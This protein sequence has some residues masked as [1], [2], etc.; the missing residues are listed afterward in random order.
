MRRLFFVG[1]A[2]LGCI[3][4]MREQRSLGV[5]NSQGCNAE[6]SSLSVEYNTAVASLLRDLSAQH[7]DFQ[8][9]FFNTGSAEV[10]AACCGLGSDNAMFGCTPP[11]RA[12][13]APTGATT[14]SGTSSIPR[15]SL[16][17][18]SRGLP[19]TGRRRWFRQ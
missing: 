12:R 4:L 8:Y 17:R 15:S 13:S 6:A 2:P 16:H 1:A 3:P 19:S 5:D 11:R 9:S 7:S 10:K 18:S 14:S